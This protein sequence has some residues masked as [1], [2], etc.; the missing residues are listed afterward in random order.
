MSL[1]ATALVSATV[2]AIVT[3]LIEWAAKPHLEARKERILDQDRIRRKLGPESV[4]FR[5][6]LNEKFKKMLD[7]EIG[8]KSRRDEE[9][10]EDI[11]SFRD[12]LIDAKHVLRSSFETKVVDLAIRAFFLYDMHGP[13]A[14]SGDRP[15]RIFLRSI[16]VFD[17]PRWRILKRHRQLR[18]A[19]SEWNQQGKH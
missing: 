1:L 13:Y 5:F 4:K 9:I 16:Q 2:A 12:L 15:E 8:I 18:K 7:E 11:Q 14:R 3:L 10:L 6:A 17:I 19:Q